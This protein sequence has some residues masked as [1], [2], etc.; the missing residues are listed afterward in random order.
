M[1]TLPDALVFTL[2]LHCGHN[3]SQFQITSAT[4]SI[5]KKV[6]LNVTCNGD[7]HFK[8]AESSALTVW[9][10]SERQEKLGGL[11]VIGESRRQT[12]IKKTPSRSTNVGSSVQYLLLLLEMQHP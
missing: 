10:D 9:V 12:E 11:A 4:K 5:H 2:P 8:K 6:Y 3:V 1:K 7:V